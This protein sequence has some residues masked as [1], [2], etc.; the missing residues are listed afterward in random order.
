MKTIRKNLKANC[1]IL[2]ILT[3]CQS[4][5][6]YHKV[7]VTIEQAAK[8]HT[9]T[10]ILLEDGRIEKFKRITYKD[11]Q[12]YGTRMT[13]NGQVTIPININSI[14]KVQVKNKTASILVTVIP[15]VALTA[16]IIA[17]SSWSIGSFDDSSWEF[18]SN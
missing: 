16:L 6:V 13:G 4:C 8:E 12:Y 14:N 11:E 5:V 2:M 15:V 10:K 17:A 18:G 1:C 3:I 9:K 7:P